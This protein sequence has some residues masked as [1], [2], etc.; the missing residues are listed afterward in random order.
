ME[1]MEAMEAGAMA[2]DSRGTSRGTAEQT[3]MKGLATEYIASFVA[4]TGE[5]DRSAAAE[6][7]TA[8]CASLVAAKA[9]AVTSTG[10]GAKAAGVTAGRETTPDAP[11]AE[12]G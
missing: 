6:R 3:S 11:Y 1:A 4:T 7:Q 10:A 9:G 8:E 12:T 5:G 2:V